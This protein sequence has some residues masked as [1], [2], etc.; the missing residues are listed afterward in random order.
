MLHHQLF[1]FIRCAND[2]F[3][4]LQSLSYQYYP[5]ACSF[6]SS[7]L[8]KEQTNVG[9]W[10]NIHLCHVYQPCWWFYRLPN[11]K[12]Q[13]SAV[14]SQLFKCQLVT[15]LTISWLNISYESVS[16]SISLNRICDAALLGVPFNQMYGCVYWQVCFCISQVYSSPP[17]SIEILYQVRL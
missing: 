12:P 2:H 1:Q 14:F 7:L 9:S 11:R 4:Y 13:Y 5:S 6:V 8:F 3:H 15:N 10:C 16:F 17:S